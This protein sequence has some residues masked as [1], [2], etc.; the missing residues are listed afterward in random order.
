ML[1]NVN[2]KNAGV[3]DGLCGGSWQAG[4]KTTNHSVKWELCTIASSVKFNITLF[5]WIL[6]L[7][8]GGRCHLFTFIQD[9]ICRKMSLY[10]EESYVPI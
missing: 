2:V 3:L 5:S 8:G 4:W 9:I 7:A 1:I 6:T 10:L